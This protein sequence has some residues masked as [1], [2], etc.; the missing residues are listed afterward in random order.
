MRTTLYIGLAAALAVAAT[1]APP[2]LV[3]LMAHGMARGIAVLGVFVLWRCGLASFGHALYIGVSAYTVAFLDQNHGIQD[4]FARAFCGMFAAGVLGFV[5]GFVMRRYRGIYFA[6]LNLAVSMVFYGL[7]VRS[8]ALGS[9]DGFVLSRMTLFGASPHQATMFLCLAATAGVLALL[10]SA[11]L[12][13][14]AGYLAHAIRDNELRLEF[15]GF[16]GKAA[17]HAKYTLSAVLCGIGGAFMASLLG[18]V[19]PDS[20]VNWTISGELVLIT[21]LAGTAS[22]VAPIIVSIAFEIIRSYALD[23]APYAWQLL[24]G[25]CLVVAVLWRP[26]GLWPIA[27]RRRHTA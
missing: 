15:L 7:V 4:L 2:W 24:F 17:V 3:D 1:S 6:M 23:I 20:M 13:S 12:R 14:T 26:N 10:L 8:S 18:Q 5:V 25:S 16:S 21:V 22:A 9:T 19:D 27:A 11:Y